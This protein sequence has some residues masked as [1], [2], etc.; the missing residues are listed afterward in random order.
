MS[1][2]RNHH[3]RFLL[4]LCGLSLAIISC[5]PGQSPT[6]APPILVA[7]IEGEITDLTRD[8][9][10]RVIALG[11]KSHAAAIVFN[12]NTPGGAVSSAMEISKAI[13]DTPIR[14]L[15]WANPEA[16]SGG[17]LIA[18]ACDEILVGQRARLGDCAGI[19]IG[20]MGLVPLGD[21]E[22]AKF[23]SY[24]LAEFRDSALAHGYPMP[25]CEAMVK[26]SP[27]IYRIRHDTTG[28]KKYVF[29][30]ELK[31]HGLN[32]RSSQALPL[33]ERSAT[34]SPA[35]GA[36][37]GGKTLG[38]QI[39]KKVL[40]EKQLLT[41]LEEEAL[42]YGFAKARAYSMAEVA[43]Y[44]KV[45]ATALTAVQMNWTEMFVA[46]LTSNIVRSILTIVMLMALYSEMQ[47]PGMGLMGAVAVLCLL[48]LMGAPYLSGMANLLEICLV[49]AGLT[50]LGVELFLI[51]G[52]GLVG[53]AGIILLV[54]GLVL[55][56]VPEEPVPGFLPSLPDS[57]KMMWRGLWTVLIAFAIATV[58]I[59]L[60]ARYF[61][62]LPMFGRMVLQGPGP[63]AATVA[64]PPLRSDELRIGDAGKTI[65]PL[66]PVGRAEFAGRIVHVTTQGELIAPDTPIRIVHIHGNRIVVEQTV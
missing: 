36:A 17:A 15:T 32:D 24:I 62:A 23:D 46:F 37:D 26:L 19:M 47:T 10:R 35:K 64:A 13:K 65:A 38:W 63:A 57:Q 5:L 29:A 40:E 61:G 66:R 53:V 3:R 58:G 21:T 27:A 22:R 48:M 43:Q 59:A 14:T 30:T 45:D 34:Q 12:M 18:L 1:I 54:L 39:D 55:T 16:I 60:L 52:F 25:L 56:F 20:P 28:E 8:F 4:I 33:P 9:V 41:M 51:P 42:E 50:L 44:L 2:G 49:I 6:P 11:E 31:D 7:T